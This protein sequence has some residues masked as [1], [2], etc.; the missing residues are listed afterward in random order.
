MCLL[1]YLSGLSSVAIDGLLPPIEALEKHHTPACGAKPCDLSTQFKLPGLQKL[2][3]VVAAVASA[4]QLRTR[5]L[6]FRL[7]F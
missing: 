5:S 7:Q 1:F 6:E 2:R 4:R 3:Q